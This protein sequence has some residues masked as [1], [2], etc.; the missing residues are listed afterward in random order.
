MSVI[1]I[2]PKDI[3]LVAGE[4]AIATDPPM[5]VNAMKLTSLSTDKAKRV[6][7]LNL[8][9]TKQSISLSFY[10]FSRNVNQSSPPLD[11]VVQKK[12]WIQR[13]VD[14]S[15]TRTSALVKEFL[16]TRLDALTVTHL[17]FFAVTCPFSSGLVVHISSSLCS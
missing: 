5:A 2:A 3:E 15:G 17:L 12:D 13:T 10:G 6:L 11:V 1:V 4:P 7:S 9:N 16:V 14:K 8:L